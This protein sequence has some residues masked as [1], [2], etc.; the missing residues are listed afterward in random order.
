MKNESTF[1]KQRWLLIQVCQN[2]FGK[3]Y[4]YDDDIFRVLMLNLI[5]CSPSSVT[6]LI[7]EIYMKFN[8]ETFI[9]V[10]DEIQVL[11]TVDKRKFRSRTNEQEERSLLS[12][13]VQ[14]PAS[15]VSDNRCFIP[16]G[17]GLGILSLEE[18][19]NTRILKPETDIL[20]FT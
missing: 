3:I 17:T 7:S 6:A 16:Y 20:K 15:S 4:S 9:I 8:K 10:L 2:I 13:I 5:A 14:E 1:N 11:K 12:P 18:V 19:L